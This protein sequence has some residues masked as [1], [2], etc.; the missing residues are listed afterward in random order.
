VGTTGRRFDDP[1]KADGLAEDERFRVV[2]DATH[3]AAAFAETI[4]HFRLDLAA[5][6][7]L[8]AIRDGPGGPHLLSGVV[9]ARWRQVRGVG[10]LLLDPALRFVDVAHPDAPAEIQHPPHLRGGSSRPPPPH[11][12]RGAL[13]PRANGRCR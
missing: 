12:A 1:G 7:A 4:A 10:R 3:R 9:P 6:A 13:R 5:L 2:Y 8:A 11:P